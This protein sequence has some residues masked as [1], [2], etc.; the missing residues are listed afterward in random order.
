MI[1]PMRVL[2]VIPSID[3]RSGGPI[4]A[5]AGLATAQSRAGLAVTVLSTYRD[6]L[7][8][9]DASRLRSAGIDVQL[10][11]PTSGKLERH[12]DLAA[13]VDRLVATADV[14]HLHGVWEELQHLTARTCQRRGVPY[15]VTPHGMLTHWSLGQSR[16]PKRLMLAWRV[17]RNLQR[18]AALHFTTEPERHESAAVRLRTP[19]LV[20]TLGL[21]LSEFEQLPL[22]GTFRNCHP[23]IA[24]RPL[25]LF[26][27][28][29][30]PGKG[31]EYLVPAMAAVPDAILAVVGPD[32]ENFRAE[33]ERR[34]TRAGVADRI[35]FTGMLAGADRVAALADADL[36]CLPSDHENFG[37][38]I[39]EALAAGV[40]AVISDRVA[41]WKELVEAGVA[42]ATPPTADAVGRELRR[43]LDDSAMR[44]AAAARTRPFVWSRYDW[45]RIAERWASH[46][47]ALRHP[48]S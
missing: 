45:R 31:L 39:V 33:V 28:R 47:A 16:W 12:P 23:Q 4:T 8:V 10:V 37:L 15:V 40:P 35:V 25:V 32:S 46:Y 19:S 22:R 2:H 26:L 34:A 38:A 42:A 24:Q 18:A 6:S 44:T 20:E 17:H 29:I 27:G 7:G 5:L 43:W 9:P 48:E 21:D 3:A 11:G 1:P 41:I 36:F 14:A 13:T 30:H